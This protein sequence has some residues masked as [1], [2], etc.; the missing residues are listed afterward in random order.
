[1][2]SENQNSEQADLEQVKIGEVR[3]KNVSYSHIQHIYLLYI[4]FSGE[5]ALSGIRVKSARNNSE[6]YCGWF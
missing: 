2:P 6:S 1:M 3:T 4:A 5:E